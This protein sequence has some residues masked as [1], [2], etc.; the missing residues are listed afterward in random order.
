MQDK[1]LSFE[2]NSD[3]EES[4]D[5]Y[6]LH[7]ILCEIKCLRSEQR[8]PVNYPLIFIVSAVT[9]IVTQIIITQL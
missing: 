5:T 6:L 1:N 7:K 3:D 8:P 4:Y 2:R 9:S